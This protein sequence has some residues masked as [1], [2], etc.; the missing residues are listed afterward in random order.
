MRFIKETRINLEVEV[1]NE[2]F[3]K[4]YNFFQRKN[5]EKNIFIYFD[6]TFSFLTNELDQED[7]EEIAIAISDGTGFYE[8]VY[9][10]LNPEDLENDTYFILKL[11]R[12]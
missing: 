12:N 11:K 7:M 2:Q 5:K 10:N 9:D 1:T 3:E 8:D 4:L 6:N